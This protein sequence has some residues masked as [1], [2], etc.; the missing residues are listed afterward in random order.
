LFRTVLPVLGMAC[1]VGTVGLPQA[2]TRLVS[3]AGTREKRGMLDYHLVAMAATAVAS[4]VLTVGTVLVLA[5]VSSYS[6]VTDAGFPAL[7]LLSIPLLLITCV[8]STLRGVL[9]GLGL[10]TAV[11]ASQICEVALRLLIVMVLPGNFRSTVDMAGAKAGIYIVT[12]SEASS[13]LFLIGVCGWLMMAGRIPVVRTRTSWRDHVRTWWSIG[14][15]SISPTAQALLTSAGYALELPLAEHYLAIRFDSHTAD[16]LV[17]EY[18]AVAIPLLCL[19]MFVTDGMATALLPTM[20]ARRAQFG[21]ASL[22][23]SLYQTVRVVAMFAVPATAA[24]FVL[25]R[26]LCAWFG[27][28]TAAQ[29]L[30]WLAPLALPL[31]LQ[32]PVASILQAQ[33]RGRALL[34]ASLFGDVVRIGTLYWC[35]DRWQMALAGLVF[36]FAVSTLLQALV[37]LGMAV[38]VTPIPVPW[39]TLCHS[40]LCSVVVSAILIAGM[41]APAPYQITQ[42]PVLWLALSA[43]AALWFYLIA[44]ELSPHTLSRLPYVG[45]RLFSTRTTR[46]NGTDS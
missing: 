46:Y 23:P 14:R 21:L 42:F 22:G 45:A 25:A 4:T 1:A 41:H 18:A 39:V 15:M 11:A 13:L 40:V 26:P 37:L 35:L 33:G 34:Y 5:D 36:A 8:S 32:A 9:L 38:H 28:A 43:S 19:P 3:A 31:Y 2:L 30:V 44:E 6:G 17:A 27:A 20:T 29:V 7:L 16:T 24:L 10:T 12:A